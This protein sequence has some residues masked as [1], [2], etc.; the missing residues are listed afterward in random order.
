MT[1]VLAA[2]T[3]PARLIPAGDLFDGG[4]ERAELLDG[5]AAHLAE[6]FAA[7]IAAVTLVLNDARV[8]SLLG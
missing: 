5:V 4:D 8:R 7:R 6:T 1:A 3:R 2:L